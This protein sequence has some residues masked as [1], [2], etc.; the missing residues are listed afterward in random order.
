M[1]IQDLITVKCSGAA[2]LQKSH[3]PQSESLCAIRSF[4]E[5]DGKCLISALSIVCVGLIAQ[6]L[7]NRL[8]RA[9]RHGRVI[10]PQEILL[11]QLM[12]LWS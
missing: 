10:M 2:R 9:S 8:Q 12:S 4:G 3:V 11:S 6:R 1:C 5:Q 7:W